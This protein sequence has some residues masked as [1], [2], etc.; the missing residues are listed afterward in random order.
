MRFFGILITFLI[1][2]FIDAAAAP[3]DRLDGY[4]PAG[5]DASLSVGRGPTFR[6][7]VGQRLGEGPDSLRAYVALSVPNDHLTFLRS[8]QGGYLATF[9]Y[10]VTLFKDDDLLPIERYREVEVPVETFRLTNSRTQYA[11]NSEEFVVAPGDYRIR[12]LLKDMETKRET[13][14]RGEIVL[15][16]S[17]SL[18]EVSDLYWVSKDER[19]AEL[20]MPRLVESFSKD[21][22]Q[23]KARVEY[24]SAGKEPMRLFWAV[25]DEKGDTIRHRLSKIESTNNVQINEYTVMLEGLPAAS[26]QLYFEIDGNGRRETRTRDFSV[27]LPGIPSSI[28]DLGLAIRQVKYIATIEE[29]R[30]LRNASLQDR[31]RLFKEFWKKRDPNPETEENELMQEYYFRIE[32]ANENYSTHRAGWESDRGRI[33][34]LYGEPTQIE[35]HPF[36]AGSRPYEIW[37]YNNINRQFVFVDYTGFGDYSLVSPQWGY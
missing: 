5:Q 28:N 32:Y 36:E 35:R 26:Y 13:L 18:L 14:W 34:A 27:H 1:I 23:V 24:F 3:R 9:E 31:E 8:E 11:F 7:Q 16:R 37:F 12:V 4:N 22:S 15:V 10:T 19:L 6:C 30:R 21:E 25:F 2:A 20:G 17:D 29:N 33:Y